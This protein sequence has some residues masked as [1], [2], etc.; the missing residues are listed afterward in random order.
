[1]MTGMELALAA[2]AACA[3]DLADRTALHPGAH[4]HL[5]AR[6]LAAVFAPALDP[7]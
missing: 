1:M 2:V 6:L 3:L 4:Y 5:P 7:M